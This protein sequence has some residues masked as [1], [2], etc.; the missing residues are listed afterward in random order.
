MSTEEKLLSIFNEIFDQNLDKVSVDIS[1]ENL[2]YWDSFGHISFM[3]ACE[4]EF[5]V[6]VDIETFSSLTNLSSISNYIAE[7]V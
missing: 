5:E 7:L 3:A 6:S 4:S 2:D 1:M